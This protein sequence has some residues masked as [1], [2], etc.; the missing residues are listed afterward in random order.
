[1]NVESKSQ[2]SN[3]SIKISEWIKNS[4]KW[5]VDDPITDEEFVNG[6]EYL[7]NARIIITE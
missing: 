7:I 4:A 3:T 5:W 6:I 2:S 1:M